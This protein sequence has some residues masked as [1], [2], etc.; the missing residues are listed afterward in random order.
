MRR[1]VCLGGWEVVLRDE[2]ELVAGL[3]GMMV[4]GSI[5]YKAPH[6][7]KHQL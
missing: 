2:A 3:R 6:P 1:D 7:P 4:L 5:L